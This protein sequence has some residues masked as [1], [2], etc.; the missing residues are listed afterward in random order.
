M[1]TYVR[2]IRNICCECVR[3]YVYLVFKFILAIIFRNRNDDDDD[4]GKIYRISRS[5]WKDP[6]R[7][8]QFIQRRFRRINIYYYYYHY[9][10]KNNTQTMDLRQL[11]RLRIKRSNANLSRRFTVYTHK[12]MHRIT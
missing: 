6:F 7:K 5:P 9:F 11:R 1:G 10:R 12:R 4:D 8:P 2:R 3:F